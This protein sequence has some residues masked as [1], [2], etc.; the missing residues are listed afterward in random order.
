DDDINRLADELPGVVHDHHRA[1][2]EIGDTLVVLLAFF[3]DEHLHDLAGQH[4]G[5][6]RVGQ[7]VDIEDVHTSKLGDLVQIEVVGDDSPLQRPREIDELE[8]HFTNV[9]KVH[10]GDDHRDARHLLNPLQNVEAAAPAVPSEC[11]T[12]I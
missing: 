9:G 5:L 1:V 2:V 6:E 8:V 3:Q 10:I 7:L 11:I 12:R 4:D